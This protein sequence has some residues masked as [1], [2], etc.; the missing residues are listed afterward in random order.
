MEH[1]QSYEQAIADGSSAP[2]ATKQ[3]HNTLKERI[4]RSMNN[5]AGGEARVRRRSSLLAAASALA[6]LAGGDSKVAVADTTDATNT[7]MVDTPPVQPPVNAQNDLQDERWSAASTAEE[8]PVTFPEK[9]MTV[10][11]NDQLSDVITWLPHGK[12]FIILQKKKFAT[13]VMPIYFKHSKFTSFTRKLNRWGFTRVP[14]GPEAGSYYHKYFQRGN[15]HLCMQMHCQSKP[16]ANTSPRTTPPP[17]IESPKMTANANPKEDPMSPGSN[18][19]AALSDL[20][21]EASP[22]ENKEQE[23]SHRH[24]DFK[25]TLSRQQEFLR[26]DKEDQHRKE[27]LQEEQFGQKPS[28]AELYQVSRRH[29]PERK[30]KEQVQIPASF[31]PMPPLAPPGSRPNHSLLAADQRLHQSLPPSFKA[32]GPFA[33]QR[34]NQSLPPSFD[35]PGTFPHAASLRNSWNTEA[36][37][38]L[39]DSWNTE[40]SARTNMSTSPRSERK[41]LHHLQDIDWSKIRNYSLQEERRDP[42][43]HCRPYL[44]TPQEP[45]VASPPTSYETMLNDYNRNTIALD[46]A[47]PLTQHN[48]V[49]RNALDAL[50]ASML[51]QDQAQ[52]RVASNVYASDQR[53]LHTAMQN[54]LRQ[55]EEQ[56]QQGARSAH[57]EYVHL[58]TDL[59]Q[60]RVEQLQQ[61]MKFLSSNSF[62]ANPHLTQPNPPQKG[63][64]PPGRVSRAS[65][66]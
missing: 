31:L 3:R 20:R 17:A 35:A 23:S 36:S 16:T 34:H 22:L 2:D 64:Y 39:R 44:A 50:K 62:Q 54:R 19:A 45:A 51:M 1:Y 28:L 10:L 32:P 66:A 42:G 38:S 57:S 65:A 55:F 24:A 29:S 59:A 48:H 18:V 30:M 6:S 13:E 46:S 53:R 7:A 11:D 14:R 21:V 37:A 49:I 5:K 12:G 25:T 60:S 47:A 43:Y 26:V 63:K 61:H 56:N 27:V 8:V 33:D 15:H 9:L 58:P 40:L 41:R 4:K 52:G